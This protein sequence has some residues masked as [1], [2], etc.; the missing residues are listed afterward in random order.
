MDYPWTLASGPDA[1]DAFLHGLGW[2]GLGWTRLGWARLAGLNWAGLCT[3]L[4]H[5]WALNQCAACWHYSYCD[6]TCRMQV[7]CVLLDALVTF[8]DMADLVLPYTL[9]CHATIA[10]AVTFHVTFAAC[11]AGKLYPCPGHPCPAL[12]CLALVLCCMLMPKPN[13]CAP[14]LPARYAKY[15]MCIKIM[16]SNPHVHYK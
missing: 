3:A 14:S 12:F 6:M 15:R 13:S 1:V 11:I 7:P 5:A 16:N 4:R 9:T 8:C 10:C 2:A